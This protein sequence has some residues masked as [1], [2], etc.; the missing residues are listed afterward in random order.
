VGPTEAL[1]AILRPG[2]VGEAPGGEV[3]CVVASRDRVREL[4]AHGPTAIVLAAVLGR[5]DA[6]ALPIVWVGPDG[7]D[8]V[9][10][11]NVVDTGPEGAAINS[12]AGR[13]LS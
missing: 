11:A 3:A 9:P 12:P 13:T 10:L 2:L 6:T 7:F 8:V 1:R 5:L 4:L